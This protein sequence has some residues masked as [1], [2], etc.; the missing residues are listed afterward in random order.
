MSLFSKR[1]RIANNMMKRYGL[2]VP[3]ITCQPEGQQDERRQR[4]RLDGGLEKRRRGSQRNF[5]E[6]IS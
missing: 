1:R 4:R 3:K 6:L 5:E 2:K